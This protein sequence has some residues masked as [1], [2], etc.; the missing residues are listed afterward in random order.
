MDLDYIYLVS[1]G[2]TGI[3]DN[4]LSSF[5]NDVQFSSQKKITE[6]A[7]SEIIF[8]DVFQSEFIPTDSGIP[9]IICSKTE[10]TALKLESLLPTEKIYLPIA[11][12]TYNG[13][14]ESINKCSGFHMYSGRKTLPKKKIYL[15]YQDVQLQKTFFWSL[16]VSKETGADSR[17]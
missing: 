16:Q 17:W 7:V 11:N 14:M 12:Y 5:K 13:L 4:T 8:E 1:N 10:S 15:W 3:Y 6:I 9:S 2:S